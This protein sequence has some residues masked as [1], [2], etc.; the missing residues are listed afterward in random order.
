MISVK[1]AIKRFFH[2]VKITNFFWI[3][4]DAL[5]RVRRKIRKRKIN[6][7]IAANK[8]I[9][10]FDSARF[11]LTFGSRLIGNRDN[12]LEK[13]FDSFLENTSNPAVF[14]FRIKLDLDDDLIYFEKLKA[15][16]RKIQI[17][18]N[19]TPRGQGYADMHL[20]HNELCD[21]RSENV[22]YHIIITDDAL[23]T[24]LNWDVDLT[25]KIIEKELLTIYWIGMPNKV[26]EAIKL[27]GPNPIK[28]EPVY[29]VAGTD[30]P[31]LSINLIQLIGDYVSDLGNDKWSAFGNLFNIDSYFG[32]LLRHMDFESARICHLEIGDYFKRVGITSWNSYIWPG[33]SKKGHLRTSTL[34]AFFG[35]E[36]QNV[37]KKISS[38]IEQKINSEMR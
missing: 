7:I 13:V 29:W 14:E 38:R 31:V 12:V 36:S 28:P 27:M 2:Y 35:D 30:F 11:V 10:K 26:E 15:R 5:H 33:E 34:R 17:V 25:S 22:K 32:D 6:K 1:R 19:H 4:K 37:R 23:F 16:Y 3:L 20:W 9:T 8:T 18:F 24:M 21:Q